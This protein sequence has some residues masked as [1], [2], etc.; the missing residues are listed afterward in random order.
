MQARGVQENN[1]E[2]FMGHKVS[3]YNDIQ[4]LGVDKL[5][6]IHASANLSIR[7]RRE[8]KQAG[9]IREFVEAIDV[10]PEKIQRIQEIM[11]EPDTKPLD[12]Q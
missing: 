6:Q 3:T 8:I 7:P 4:S 12:P 11:V 9:R 2:Y 1:V 5:R 10:S